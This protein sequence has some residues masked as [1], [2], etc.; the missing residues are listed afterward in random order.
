MPKSRSRQRERRRAYVPQPQKKR[1]K[2]SPKWFGFLILGLMGLGV[3][4]IVANYMRGDSA[5]NLWLFTGLALV[6]VGF[7]LATQW[8]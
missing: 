2:A 7:G 4:I 5:Q 6:A 1:R 3:A 8:R